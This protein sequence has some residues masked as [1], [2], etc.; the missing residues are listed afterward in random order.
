MKYAAIILLIILSNVTKS[1]EIDY[2]QGLEYDYSNATA[3]H[4]NFSSEQVDLGL[5]A[6]TSQ[7]YSYGDGRYLTIPQ[8][9]ALSVNKTFTKENYSIGIGLLYWANESIIFR[10]KLNYQ[11]V[12]NYKIKNNV[13]LYIEHYGLTSITKS[14]AGLN[15]VSVYWTF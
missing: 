13:E 10:N 9:I 8:N 11:F 2:W 5:I 15:K 1:A 12:A 6:V 4:I 14:D 3:Y 7:L